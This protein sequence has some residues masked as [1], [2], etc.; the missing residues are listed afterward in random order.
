[1]SWLLMS[2]IAAAQEQFPNNTAG[3]FLNPSNA[4]YVVGLVLLFLG[5]LG[6]GVA[7]I[8]LLLRQH[9]KRRKPAGAP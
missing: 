7:F 1:M 3:N 4:G 8:G 6:V 5:L 2:A 9:L